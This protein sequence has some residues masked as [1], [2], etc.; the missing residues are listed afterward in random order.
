MGRV[1]EL[2][3]RVRSNTPQL[4][5]PNINE[6][7]CPRESGKDEEDDNSWRPQKSTKATIDS[8]CMFREDNFSKL[9]KKERK[10]SHKVFDEWLTEVIL[11]HSKKE[12]DDIEVL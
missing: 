6:R 12:M 3:N 4:A 10:K 11:K 2:R 9:T 8:M 7:L 1:D 5:K